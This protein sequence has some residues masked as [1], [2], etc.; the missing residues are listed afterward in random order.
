MVTNA[1]DTGQFLLQADPHTFYNARVIPMNVQPQ[2]MVLSRLERKIVVQNFDEC[3][4]S[5]PGLSL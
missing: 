4:G 5:H 3:R 1:H 2:S